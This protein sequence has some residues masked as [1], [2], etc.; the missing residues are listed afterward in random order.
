M[1]LVKDLEQRTDEWRAIRKGSIGG[2][3]VKSVFAKN[4]LPLIDEL[5]AER[6]SDTIEENFVKS[7]FLL[8]FLPGLLLGIQFFLELF[9]NLG[10]RPGEPFSLSQDQA[11]SDMRGLGAGEGV[12]EGNV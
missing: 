1:N 3:R 6:H 8:F 10:S 7:S 5:I 12:A 4:N 2:T 11:Q 9:G